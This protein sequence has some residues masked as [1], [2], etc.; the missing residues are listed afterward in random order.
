MSSNT[1]TSPVAGWPKVSVITVVYN[2]VQLLPGTIEAVLGMNYPNLEYLIID[3]GSTDGTLAAIDRERHRIARVVS[4]QDTGIYDA[5]NKGIAL[6]QGDYLWFLNAGDKPATPDVLNQLF[7]SG[8]RPDYVFGNTNLVD[9]VGT[10]LNVARAPATLHW[11]AMARG[12]Q[13]SHQSFLVRRGIAPRYD[14]QYRYIADQK[15]I[16]DILRATNAGLN[17]NAVLSSYLLGGLSHTLFSRFVKEK[18]RYS[19]AELGWARAALIT[20]E[21]LLKAGKFYISTARRRWL[22]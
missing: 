9:A 8:L 13:V 15:W 6:A 1:K 4:E 20:M 3:G 14:L 7:G 12:M 19:F 10:V 5:M 11:R 21:D 16:I 2:A 17:A 18:I 22:A